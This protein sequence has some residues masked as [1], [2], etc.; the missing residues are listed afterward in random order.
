VSTHPLGVGWGGGG[1][2]TS[3][4]VKGGNKINILNTN[5]L[6]FSTIHILSYWRRKF[7]Q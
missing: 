4:R 5:R 7:S 3:S 2:C 6:I 1:G